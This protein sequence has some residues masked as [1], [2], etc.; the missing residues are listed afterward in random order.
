MFRTENPVR[1]DQLKR[2]ILAMKDLTEIRPRF[3]CDSRKI[4][5]AGGFHFKHLLN[6]L[7]HE[8]D[9]VSGNHWGFRRIFHHIAGGMHL[10]ADD[11]D[12]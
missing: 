2:S 10:D 9:R 5:L 6:P 3:D 4:I 12:S 1:I 7:D 11:D 8:S